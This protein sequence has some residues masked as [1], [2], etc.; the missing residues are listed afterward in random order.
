MKCDN[1]DLYIS[2][3]LEEL[4]N[5]FHSLVDEIANI[6]CHLSPLESWLLIKRGQ[7]QKGEG[8]GRNAINIA[9]NDIPFASPPNWY[10]H[11][12]HE[13][14]SVILRESFKPLSDYLEGLWLQFGCIIY[15]PDKALHNAAAAAAMHVETKHFLQDYF[16]KVEEFNRLIRVIYGMVRNSKYIYISLVQHLSMI[17]GVVPCASAYAKRSRKGSAMFRT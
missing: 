17:N 15:K 2:P 6:A 4:Y 11:E 14:L 12:A 13:R 7:R 5:A 1:H 10:L 8:K 16:A 3:R 9:N